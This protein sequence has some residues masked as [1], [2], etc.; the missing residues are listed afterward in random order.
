MKKIITWL[1]TNFIESLGLLLIISILYSQVTSAVKV[2][3]YMRTLEKQN[4]DAQ[5]SLALASG[6]AVYMAGASCTIKTT[7]DVTV[8]QVKT[9]SKACVR[10][11]EQYLSE[12]SGHR[13]TETVKV[14]TQS[15]AIAVPQQGENNDN[16]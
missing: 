15:A 13:Q 16:K 7:P 9:L 6:K 4:E 11:H 10:A 5:T 8:D 1:R 14:D 3:E 12:S 2:A